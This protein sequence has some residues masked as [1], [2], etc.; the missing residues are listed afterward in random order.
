M[1]SNFVGLQVY[2][3]QSSFRCRHKDALKQNREAAPRSGSKA[4]N[5]PHLQ[6]ESQEF[7]YKQSSASPVMQQG[8][9]KDGCPVFVMLPLGTVLGMRHGDEFSSDI[10]KGQEEALDL[11]L[12][13]LASAK[14]QV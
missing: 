3:T 12:D 8:R 7:Q 2:T 6:E 4:L 10:Q 5:V 13:K 11:A 1:E 14:V 9:Q